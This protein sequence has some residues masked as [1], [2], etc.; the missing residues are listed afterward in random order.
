MSQFSI[1]LKR[2]KDIDDME[3][4]LIARDKRETNIS[5][6]DFSKKCD[7]IKCLSDLK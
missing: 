4:M 3:S 7:V 6:V 2:K 5:Y 1:V